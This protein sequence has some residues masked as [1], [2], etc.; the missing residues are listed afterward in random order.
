MATAL[1]VARPARRITR[2]SIAQRAAEQS[3]I[4]IDLTASPIPDVKR[5]KVS[6]LEPKK[7]P[8]LPVKQESKDLYEKLKELEESSSVVNNPDEFIC[9]L[10]N[11]IIK[12]NQGIVARECVHYTC[13]NCIREHILTTKT[14][15]VN[16]P[17]AGC[18]SSL[19]DREIR[20]LLTQNEYA[21]HVN[22]KVDYDE[23]DA[24]GDLYEKLKLLED[25][26][27]YIQALG[28]FNCGVCITDTDAEDGVTIRDCLHQFCVDCIRG[29]INNSDDAV[30]KCPEDGCEC[31]IQSR[32]IRSLLTQAEFDKYL[33]KTLRIAETVTANSF[34]CKK[35][36][37]LGWAI[38]EDEVNFF[39]CPIC[40]SVNCLACQVSIFFSSQFCR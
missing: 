40:Q 22:S 31:E 10:C 23:N 39:R 4:F 5:P 34:H 9:N 7:E 2:R 6:P 1:P 37:C 16:C 18:E 38:C 25:Q 24:D 11:L 8:A 26:S 32:E 17:I 15:D 19:Q 27:G 30:V 33:L 35:P 36:D 21:I 3:V 13:I 20:S 14:V 28:P 29:T 12:V